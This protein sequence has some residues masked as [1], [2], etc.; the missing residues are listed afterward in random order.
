MLGNVVD[1][2]T[3]QGVQRPSAACSSCPCPSVQARHLAETLRELQLLHV[4]REVQAALIAAPLPAKKSKAG[5]APAQSAAAV[6]ISKLENALDHAARC[7]AAGSQRRAGVH[8]CALASRKP[9]PPGGR[10]GIQVFV[11]ASQ[12]RAAGQ[13]KAMLS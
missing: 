3:L 12:H 10:A 8:V 13:R 7:V 11:T 2:R 6:E 1:N 4:T 9:A 5:G